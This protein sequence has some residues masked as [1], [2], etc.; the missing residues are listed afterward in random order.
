MLKWLGRLLLAL[1][2]ALLLG[3]AIGAWLRLRLERPVYYIGA[4]GTPEPAPGPGGGPP[5]HPGDERPTQGE[6]SRSGGVMA[7]RRPGADG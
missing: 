6:A 4:V 5:P 1:L 2:L 3:L 7:E